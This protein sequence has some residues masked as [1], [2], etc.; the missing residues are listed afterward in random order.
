MRRQRRTRWT[1]TYLANG[2]EKTR[3]ALGYDPDFIWDWYE[4]RGYNLIS[5]EKT[6]NRQRGTSAAKAPR[7]FSIDEAALAEAIEFFGIKQP[8]VIRFNGRLGSVAGN[9]RFRST[10]L[11][12]TAQD[13]R[14][15]GEAHTYHR[16]MIK[17]YLSPE[18]ASKTLWHELTHAM[19]AEREAGE[20]A[21]GFAGIRRWNQADARDRKYSYDVRPCEI[22]AREHEDL[23]DSLPLTVAIR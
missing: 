17:S 7:D 8:V 2:E 3:Q 11:H 6:P 9:H 23:H 14:E 18:N 22:E 16:I 13:R 12:S 19:Q 21:A 4:R 5:V 15:V 20:E 10:A 1:V